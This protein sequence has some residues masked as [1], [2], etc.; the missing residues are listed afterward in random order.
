MRVLMMREGFRRLYPFTSHYLP[1]GAH[2]LHYVDEG[3]G[4]VVVLLHGNPTWS[5]YFRGLIARLRKRFRVIAPDHMGCGLSDKP[6]RYPYTLRTHIDNLARLLDH[7]RV[8]EATLGMHDWGGAIGMGWAMDHADRVSRLMIF[9]TAAFLGPCPLRIRVCRWPIL[10]DL[11]VRGCNGFVRG[12]F[13]MATSR[14]GR[15]SRDVRAGYGFPYST[16]RRRVA[17]MRFVE[18]IP[19]SPRDESYGLV[20]RIES[21]LPQWRSRPALIGWGMQ[22]FCFH[23]GYLDRWIRLFP[24]AR[25]YRFENAG[26]YVLEDARDRIAPIVEE[27]LRDGAENKE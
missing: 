23:E 2:R 21:S 3:E 27:F 20:K 13:W 22:D 11:L 5:F 24:Q 14:P 6:A 1:I 19:L 15:L 18:D 12:S 16:V 10:G 4:P 9:N 7:L 17:I 8:Q 26:H 25:V